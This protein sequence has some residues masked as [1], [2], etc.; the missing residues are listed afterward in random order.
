M[1]AWAVRGVE[2][3]FGQEIE[4]WWIDESG[5]IHDRPVAGADLLPGGFILPE[6]PRVLWRLPIHGRVGQWEQHGSIR[7]SCV[8]G[9]SGWGWTWARIRRPAGPL[10]AG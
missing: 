1:R 3:P 8:T 4:S 2:L 9:R 10:P 6:S 5:S 7:T